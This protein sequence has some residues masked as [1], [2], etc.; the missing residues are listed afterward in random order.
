LLVAM[1]TFATEI[2]D[3]EK[4]KILQLAV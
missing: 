4:I 2:G 3:Q 1:M